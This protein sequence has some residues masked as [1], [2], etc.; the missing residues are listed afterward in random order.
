MLAPRDASIVEVC[1]SGFS[2][3]FGSRLWAQILG[4][5]FSRVDAT[6]VVTSGPMTNPATDRNAMVPVDKV[7][8]LILA[9]DRQR[10]R[11]G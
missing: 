2:G 7:R 10:A 8:E 11:D 6:P 9:A 1:L 4:Q 5:G 3:I